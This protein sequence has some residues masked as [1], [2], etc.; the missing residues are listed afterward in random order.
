MPDGLPPIPQPCAIC[1][2]LQAEVRQSMLLCSVCREKHSQLVI[3]RFLQVSAIFIGVILLFTIV[4]LPRE[5]GAAI[6]WDRG[7][8]AWDTKRYAEAERQYEATLQYYPESPSVLA[9][10]A[11]AAR[12][13]GD[14]AKFNNAMDTLGHLAKTDSDAAEEL[15]RVLMEE[16]PKKP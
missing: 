14:T 4:R 16:V 13:N 5:L 6:T 15:A 9:R 7:D 2:A 1:G 3:P 11:R 12:A 8:A 10:V